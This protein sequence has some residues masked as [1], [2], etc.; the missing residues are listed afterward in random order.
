MHLDLA[1]N[2]LQAIDLRHQHNLKSLYLSDN[3]LVDID[4]SH[5]A[6]LEQLYLSRNN[7]KGI[8][9][10]HQSKLKDLDLSENQLEAID[11]SHQKDL[12]GLNLSDNYLTTIDLSCQFELKILDLS[13]NQLSQIPNTNSCIHLQARD[14][15]GNPIT[16][17]TI[18][19]HLFQDKLTSISEFQS[20]DISPLKE[21]QA[22]F[23]LIS[24]WLDR[25]KTAHDFTS[26]SPLEQAIFVTRIFSIFNLAIKHPEFQEVLQMTLAEATTSC[27]DRAAYFLNALESYTLLFESK[28]LPIQEVLPLLHGAFALEKL[29]EISTEFVNMHK[30]P[31][32]RNQ[33]G[34]YEEDDITYIND[35]PYIDEV[36]PIEVYLG[37]QTRFKEAFNLPIVTKG[38]NY[39]SCAGIK[40]EDE[41]WA[42]E[43][44]LSKINEPNAFLHYLTSMNAWKEKIKQEFSKDLEGLLEPFHKELE[45]KIQEEIF[46]RA[47]A[48]VQKAL[49]EPIHTRMRQAEDKF[50]T[51]KTIEFLTPGTRVD[52]RKREDDDL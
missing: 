2:H 29:H 51:E 34:E 46:L 52:K 1:D 45:E 28:D 47:I 27:V 15:S 25:L 26:I 19:L 31:V 44:L 17:E 42:R 30:T 12:Q 4:L 23:N 33:L 48:D 20:F 3:Q 7:L 41:I 5:Q 24:D 36:D 43:K 22:L 50:I 32:P 10:S 6:P 18:D 13:N 39:D 49:L 21:N 8:D 11:L 37:F 16:V 9:L 14:F 40:A 38:L 35:T